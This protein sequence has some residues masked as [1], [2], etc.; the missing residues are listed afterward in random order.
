MLSFVQLSTNNSQPLQHMKEII[1]QKTYGPIRFLQ[2]GQ[3][4]TEMFRSTD[5]TNWPDDVIARLLRG[6]DSDLWLRCRN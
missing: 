2:R 4:T 3:P 5:P 1:L 6:H